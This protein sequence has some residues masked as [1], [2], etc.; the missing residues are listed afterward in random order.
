RADR[1]FYSEASRWMDNPNDYTVDNAHD[2]VQ[3]IRLM[4]YASEDEYGLHR[5]MKNYRTF[6]D[7]FYYLQSLARQRAQTVSY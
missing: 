4:H 6:D 1:M 3:A 2:Q 7:A 5:L